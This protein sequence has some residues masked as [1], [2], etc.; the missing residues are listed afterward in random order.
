MSPARDIPLRRL[1]LRRPEGTLRDRLFLLRHRWRLLLR[2]SL[3]TAA[4]YWFATHV[5]DHRQAFFAPIAA[6][7]VLIA[8]AGLRGRT[9]FELV[10][11]VSTG[12]LVGELIILLIGRGTWQLALVVVLTMI[13]GILVGLKGLA[14]TQAAT[15]SVLLAT[16]IPVAGNT[17]PAATR[18]LDAL[19]GG[20]FGLAT[21]LLIPR[22]AVR[23][24]D[25]EVQQFLTRL[26][27][28]LSRTAQALR[29]DDASLA[30]LA[31]NEARA[32]Q[33]QVETMTSTAA[34]VTEIARM[35]PMRWKQ[36]EHVETYVATV[37][38]LDNAVRDARVLARKTS[39]LLRHGE[40]V[41]PDMDLAI[42]ALAK[43]IGIFADDLSQHDDFDEARQELVEA[44]R[45]AS[46]ALP[47]A[48]T[49]NSAS[50]AAQV[51][52]LAADLLY[53]SGFSRDEIDERL[54]F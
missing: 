4:A 15:S 36:R 6:I 29:T 28:I 16:V 49:M 41:P 14:L 45:M 26:A 23:D 46:A 25:R 8:G 9:L 44:A 39:A 51:R 7:I 43:A 3:A 48:M 1:R 13:V 34:N 33:P 24:I 50:I 19:I 18:F 40:L 52:S 12:V 27:G 35:S 2:L 47:E 22:N 11:G 21:I 5:L 20:A 30:D 37:R 17:N 53:A 38:D 10:L 31:L 54:E 42:D 32:M